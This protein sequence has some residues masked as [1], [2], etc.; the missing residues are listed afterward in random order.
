MPD[1][2]EQTCTRIFRE[3]V[4]LAHSVPLQNWD[5]A[6]LLAESIEAID[7]DSLTLLD[8]VMQIEDAYDIELDEAA[9][10]SCR[11]IGEVTALVAAERR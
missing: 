1:S 8:F 10:N 9:V 6:R 5:D 3:L 4:G 2:I 11:T 7:V